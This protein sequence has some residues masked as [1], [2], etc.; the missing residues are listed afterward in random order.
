MIKLIFNRF[1]DSAS[2]DINVNLN[3]KGKEEGVKQITSDVKDVTK[4]IGELNGQP[5][6]ITTK[7]V[8]SSVNKIKDIKSMLLNLKTTKV[9]FSQSLSGIKESGLF[10]ALPKGIQT[11]VEQLTNLQNI[12][13]DPMAYTSLVRSLT[14]MGKGLEDVTKRSD[15]AASGQK[16][17]KQVMETMKDPIEKITKAIKK[18]DYT[19]LV[20]MWR[21]IRRV[22]TGL[23]DIVQN[24]AGYEE[25]INLYKL[26][27][28]QYHAAGD[29]WAKRISDKLMLDIAD[30]YQYTG[31]FFNLA[32]GMGV[33]GDAAYKMSTNLTQL[34]YD[35]ASYLNISNEA[36]QAKIQSTMAGQS[37][38][39]AT[40]GV[41]TQMASLQELAYSLNIKKK[42][43]D[44]TQAEKTYL[45]Y[46]QL[47]RSTT[48][49]QGDLG[50]TML[51]PANTIRVLKNQINLLARSIGQVLVPVLT[52]V[53]PY[54]IAFT[55]VI[56]KLIGV[57]YQYEPTKIDYS[58]ETAINGAENLEDLGNA[59]ASAGK[60]VSE[61]LAPF[62]ELNNVISESSGVGSGGVGGTDTI[63]ASFWDSLLP[64]YDMLKNYT[65]D[66]VKK[67]EDLE[68]K[69]SSIAGIIAGIV[70]ASMLGSL[71]IK[72]GDFLKSMR[73]I[74]DC[75]KLINT[76]TGGWLSKLTLALVAIGGIKL[77]NDAINSAIENAK[78]GDLEEQEART[79]HDLESY[80]TN[81]GEN[82]K[83]F[84][85][86]KIILSGAG[87]GAAA[88]GLAGSFAGPGGTGIGM[89]LGSL[90]GVWDAIF[91]TMTKANLAQREMNELVGIYYEKQMHNNEIVGKLNES[92]GK[93][94]SDMW[95]MMEKS[96]DP[97]NNAEV[98]YGKLQQIVDESGKVKKGHEAEAQTIVKEL[99]TALGLNI[100]LQDGQIKNYQKI[101]QEIDKTIEKRKA[102]IKLQV[103][104]EAYRQGLIDEK[105]ALDALSTAEK[106]R[107]KAA[108]ALRAS[109]N[110]STDAQKKAL[111]AY[112]KADEE[113]KE[114]GRHYQEILT[115]KMTWEKAYGEF[116]QG[117]Y[118][119][120]NDI[121]AQSS[122]QQRKEMI[123]GMV[124]TTNE[125][126]NG[127]IS[128]EQ[129][130][131]W[132]SLA[133][134][135]RDEFNT[136]LKQIAD[137]DTRALIL[138][139][140]NN[141]KQPVSV[142]ADETGTIYA[143]DAAYSIQEYFNDPNHAL[144]P[145]LVLPTKTPTELIDPLKKYFSEHNI[146]LNIDANTSPQ[147]IYKAFLSYFQKNPLKVAMELGKN[148]NLAS[149][150][151]GAL[152]ILKFAEGGLPT[153]G[154]LFFANENGVPEYIT[155]VGNKTAVANQGQMVQILTNAITA[156]FQ[157][158]GG[159]KASNVVVY[160]GDKKL[161]EGQGEYQT[162]QNDRYGTTVVKI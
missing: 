58:F 10:D 48:Q 139:A 62:D 126:K 17:L 35:M 82:V 83:D 86:W 144:H 95:Q 51:T 8:T 14:E 102:E 115:N 100:Q 154:D 158:F 23:V 41:A 140:I 64:E 50:R 152:K 57:F 159:N 27:L 111:E 74:S 150:V 101:R 120:V 43:K 146:P 145:K 6:T 149:G 80:V 79:P 125:I 81:F 5:I 60:S 105:K 12:T 33:T 47:M 155:S 32:K 151:L 78:K 119:T 137:P 77:T 1:G 19:Q 96:L 42:V 13:K 72:I 114:A 15:S 71:V 99:N 141:L 53:I 131:A 16:R 75:W 90:L 133:A 66:L 97:I 91:I 135:S 39:V 67:A 38:A 127:A 87:A 61:S 93:G 68:G 136:Q 88:G 121:F 108:E 124:Q 156:G 9:D 128:M 31:A 3:V 123:E 36:A 34:T 130:N 56:R 25:S 129:I 20:N 84:D 85:A 98:L 161:Y 24:A 63:P 45:R 103:M 132:K 2:Q 143:S 94:L 29:E 153:S 69:V 109:H 157:Q 7:D 122:E 118:K 106:N 22:S 107:T 21:T 59:A 113:Y 92:V 30:I 89:A 148:I 18:M 28:G 52:K 70:G 110:L 37:R 142:I 76:S 147:E 134:Y 73:E 49:M 46:I 117:H 11:S 112:Q 4:A 138:D 162:R 65:D 104:E 116:L 55:N 160:V 54:I 26:A 40:V 44:M